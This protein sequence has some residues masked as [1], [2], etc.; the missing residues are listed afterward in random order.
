MKIQTTSTEI[1]RYVT[2]VLSDTIIKVNGQKNLKSP[3]WKD[4]EFLLE[5][6]KKDIEN[7]Q[8][9]D[10]VQGLKDLRELFAIFESASHESIT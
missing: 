7:G 4:T 8:M 2:W 9:K 1:A 5:S 10:A 3:T 6:F